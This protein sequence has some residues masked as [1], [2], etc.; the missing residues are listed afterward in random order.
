MRRGEKGRM[1][2]LFFGVDLLQVGV[3][4]R[5][6]GVRGRSLYVIDAANS[7]LYTG[8]RFTI[9]AAGVPKIT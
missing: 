5:A 2:A 9:P 4:L 8:T 7:G 3:V 6:G 1:F